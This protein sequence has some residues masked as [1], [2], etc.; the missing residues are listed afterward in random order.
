MLENVTGKDIMSKRNI[1]QLL[2]I[3]FAWLPL[4]ALDYFTKRLAVTQLKGTDGVVFIPNYWDFQYVENRETAF[5]L[6]RWIPANIRIPI[7]I[8]VALATLLVI[9]WYVWRAPR[10]PLML[11][12]FTAIGAGAIGNLLDRFIYGFVVDFIHW[13]IGASFD[14]PV[15]N[16]AD[17]LMVVGIGLLLLDTWL[18]REEAPTEAGLTQQTQ[19]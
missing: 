18:T 6:T 8:V 1:R 19:L 9:A 4:V 2:L 17:S 16:L 14:W 15:F 3:I 5:N 13:H 10:R 12:A 11:A 7:I